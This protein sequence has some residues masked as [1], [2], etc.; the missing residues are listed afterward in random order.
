MILRP[1]RETDLANLVKYANNPKIAQNMTD[2]FPQ[3]YTE[4][5]GKVF[6]QM[7]LKNSPPSILAITIDD[8]FVGGIGL[9]PQADVYRLNAELGYWLAEPFWG[10]GIVTKAIKEMIPYGFANLPI[11]RIFAR[12]FGSNIASQRVLEKAGFSLE[13][14]L[15]KTLIKNG[16]IED[17]LIYA[18]RNQ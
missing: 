8:E 2:A 1:F 3:P 17:E 5:A 4:D 9:H 6:I 16:L 10:Q 18:V 13:A 11:E 12:P 15:S 14:R 7:A